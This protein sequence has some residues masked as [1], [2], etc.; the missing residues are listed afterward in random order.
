MAEF[1]REIADR[2]TLAAKLRM[3]PGLNA[4]VGWEKRDKLKKSDG[5]DWEEIAQAS[6]QK[7]G[8]KPH[9]VS[10]PKG[11]LEAV[12]WLNERLAAVTGR[13][14]ML[15]RG[16]VREL[17]YPRWVADSKAFSQAS[18]WVPQIPL[19]EGVSGLFES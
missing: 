8:G 12:A 9:F 7:R 5:Y 15:S 2:E 13:A 19:A 11:L 6:M 1:N 3:L 4:G 18:G 16:K 14:I 10:L 17:T